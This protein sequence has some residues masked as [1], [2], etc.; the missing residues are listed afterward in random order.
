[1]QKQLRKI[2]HYLKLLGEQRWQAIV[3]V[4]GIT[5]CPSPTYKTGHTPP[6]EAAFV[7]FTSGDS[8]G[9]GWDTHAWFRFTV[10]RADQQDRDPLYLRAHTERS[11][12]DADN[13][14]F[15][16]YV[17]GVLRQ[18]LD[19]NHREV[20]LEGKGPFDVVLYAYTGPKVSSA[21]FFAD[22]RRLVPEVNDLYYDL[23]YPHQ[24]LDYLDLESDEYAQI[25][26][27]LYR[28]V[29]MLDLYDITAP[30][31]RASAAEAS[32]YLAAEFYGKYCRPQPATTVCIGHTHIDCAWKWT[33]Q[34][35]REKVQRSFATVLE[36]MRLYPEYKFMSSQALLY[37]NLKE[38]APE[39]YEQV[40]ARIAEGRW[41]CEGAMWVEAD[42]N[43]SSGESLV[44]QVLYGKRFFKE[45]FG[46]DNHIL[47]L[48]D[49]FGYSAALPQILRKS[50][51]DWFVTS[52][53]SWNDTN[54]MP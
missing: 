23:L 44:R 16:V 1:M 43:L 14:Q 34:Q 52:K 51:V 28:A 39:L 20:L 35:T 5:V 19:T 54:R 33:L 8:F 25:V 7:P 46:V 15:I 45:E 42:C 31:F 10:D 38:E 13:P 27:Y 4:E 26:K 40:R 37:Q 48:P 24:M 11:G 50:G 36:L 41:E 6:P 2:K 47:W 49:V 30:E 17:D 29:S 12:W 9:S 53:I 3:P 21:R 22:T 18:G 32:A